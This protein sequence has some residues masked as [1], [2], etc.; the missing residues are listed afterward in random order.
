MKNWK[1]DC[2][3]DAIVFSNTSA[4]IVE[5]NLIEITGDTAT[6]NNSNTITHGD[7]LTFLLLLHDLNKMLA[8]N[9]KHKVLLH[10][11]KYHHQGL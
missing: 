2:R 1:I 8:E 9:K 5:N 7:E 6:Y 10:D 3:I 11:D 4:I